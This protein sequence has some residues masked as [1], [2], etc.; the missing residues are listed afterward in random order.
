MSS[1]T[2]S[3]IWGRSRG[4]AVARRR[5]A[6]LLLVAVCSAGCGAATGSGSPTGGS[7][8]AAASW[9]APLKIPGVHTL[10]AVSCPTT[11]FCMAVGG[12]QA[13]SYAN[14]QWGT[15]QTPGSGLDAVSCVSSSFCLAGGA[16]SA[17]V[18][19][20]TSW[21]TPAGVARA[22]LTQIS[23]A[24]T[25]FCGAVDVQGM[26]W[27]FNGSS[28]SAPKTNVP[29]VTIFY[30]SCPSSGF[31]MG[32]DNQATDTSRLQNGS[33][34]TAGD[35]SVSTPQGGSEPN[36]GSGVSCASPSFC[37]ALDDFGEAFT[38]TGGQWSPPAHFDPNL[39]D[40]EDA[41][42][43]PTA[44][45][46]M[47]VDEIGIASRWDGHSWS[48]PHRIDGD[49]AGLADVSCASAQFCMAVDLRGRALVYR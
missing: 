7:P 33:W 16:H 27:L 11:G 9:S 17:F 1:T 12:H 13:I 42:S 22:N 44:N 43:C 24:T 35:L 45:T 48:S 34:S 3:P 41:V 5:L 47:V 8:A 36:T 37:V 18:Y 28:W 30:I 39:M 14:G 38:W 2:K 15:A 19:N 23:C 20:G 40:E 32:D 4:R 26:T 6:P 46:C 21:S 25:T 31:C 49:E 29:V 10:T